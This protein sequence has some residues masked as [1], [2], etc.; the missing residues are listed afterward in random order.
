MCVCKYKTQPAFYYPN[1]GDYMYFAI[2]ANDAYTDETYTTDVFFVRPTL[3]QLY[4]KFGDP[5]DMQGRYYKWSI[6]V[7]KITNFQSIDHV[8]SLQ[9]S[10]DAW[11][12]DDY[13]ECGDGYLYEEHEQRLTHKEKEKELCG[14]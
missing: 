10:E 12:D 2:I 7:K 9:F 6:L 3:N 8:S 1:I 14:N 4:D 11:P 13:I 5:E